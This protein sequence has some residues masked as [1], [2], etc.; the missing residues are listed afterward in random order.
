MS[1]SDVLLCLPLTCD[2]LLSPVQCGYWTC[3][4]LYD[5]VSAAFHER[6]CLSDVLMCLPLMC[7]A[8]LSAVYVAVDVPFSI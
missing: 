5:A 6:M 8:P 1:L 4:S 2:A 7:E 3:L